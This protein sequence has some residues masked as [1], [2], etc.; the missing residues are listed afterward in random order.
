MLKPV[1]A[2][3]DKDAGIAGLNSKTH[4]KILLKWMTGRNVVKLT[5]VHVGNAKKSSTPGP[6][7]AAAAPAHHRHPHRPRSDG[8]SPLSLGVVLDVAL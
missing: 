8:Q 2:V 4:M 5:C 1:A 6:L 7:K 3:G